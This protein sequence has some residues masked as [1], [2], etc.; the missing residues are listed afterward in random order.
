LTFP[1]DFLNKIINGDCL[2]IMKQMPDKCV[3]L[4]LTDPPYGIGADKNK[5][6]NQ[7]HGKAAAISKDY[8]V[9]DWDDAP[10][11][12]EIFDEIFRVSKN[13]IIFGGNYFIN[14]LT[15]SSCWIVWDKNNGDNGYAD[16]ELAWTSFKTAV[17]KYKYTWHGMIQENMKYKEVRQ[18]PTQKPVPVMEWLLENYSE[19]GQIILD[20]FAGSGTTLVAAQKFQRPYIGIEISPEYC[21]IAEQRLKQQVLNF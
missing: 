1:D 17:R 10:P 19:P 12:K 20:P 4:V 11:P 21:K 6:A 8:G 2:E 14:H 5:R 7:K 16:C 15:P 13:Q 9:G 3:D 18:H